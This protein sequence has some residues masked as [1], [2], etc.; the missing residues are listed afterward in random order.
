[1]PLF[2]SAVRLRRQVAFPAA[3]GR[4][5]LDSGGFSELQAHGA[6]TVSA[7]Q[8]AS[9]AMRWSVE[10]G[11]PDFV[12]IQDWMCEPF[13]LAKTG[14]SVAEHQRLT[15]ESY[16]TLRELAPHVPW[17]PVVQG[18][19]ADDYE[20]HVEQYREQ[21]FDL[22]DSAVVGVG[23]VCRRQGTHEGAG[24]VERVASLGIRV[25]A[26]GVKVDGLKL[27]GERIASA[28]SMTWSFVARRR[29]IRMPQCR[30]PV[31]SNCFRWALEWHRTRI[32]AELAEPRDM[33]Q[34]SFTE[35]W[36]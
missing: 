29:G 16:A 26:F 5:A 18:W 15:I 10:V 4:W 27:F 3:R 14:K 20:S 13:M 12:A 31:C 6:W 11:A 34:L 24:I 23:S 19:Q 17:M 25:H 30:H 2:V 36:S 7:R 22:R 28:D 35:A 32:G 1:V 33:A 9:E 8:Y 21:G